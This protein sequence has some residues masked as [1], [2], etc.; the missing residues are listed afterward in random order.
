M[1]KDLGAVRPV[2]VERSP[3]RTSKETRR[4]ARNERIQGICEKAYLQPGR[5]VWTL[6]MSS[7]SLCMMKVMLVVRKRRGG[8]E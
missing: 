7:E 4:K 6:D 2:V 3:M 1:A 5:R 8:E